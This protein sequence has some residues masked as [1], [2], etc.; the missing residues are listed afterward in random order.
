LT[1]GPDERADPVAIQQVLLDGVRMCGLDLLP[2]TEA[3]IALRARASFAG[4][5]TLSDDLLLASLEVWLAPLIE[6]RLDKIP[7]DAL[8]DALRNRLG[9]DAQR[10][11]NKAAPAEFVSPA[12]TRH[13]INYTADGGPRVELRVQALFGLATHPTVGLGIPLV[14]SLTSPAGRP[15]QTTRD[16]AGFWAGSWTDVAKEMRGRYPRH[17]WPDDPTAAVASLRTK[18]AQSRDQNRS[19]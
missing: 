8:T 7:P 1:S 14:L 10:A 17:N 11:I 9:W 5:D 12:G 2:W 16:L 18:N 15:I 6:R 13:A 4:N 3:A 19:S